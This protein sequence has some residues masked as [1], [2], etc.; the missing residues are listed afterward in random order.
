MKTEDDT[1]KTLRVNMVNFSL[2]ADMLYELNFIP[3]LTQ[4]QQILNYWCSNN[5]I[6][7]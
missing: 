4:I 3:K 5:F 1:F 6:F 2:N 7:D